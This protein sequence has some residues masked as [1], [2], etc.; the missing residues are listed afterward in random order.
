MSKAIT[1][2][3]PLITLSKMG[4]LKI[5]RDVYDEVIIPKAVLEEIKAK[6]D[7]VAKDVVN[8]LDWLKVID[9]PEVDRKK[10][11]SILHAG[12]IEAIVLAQSIGSRYFLIID[13]QAAKRAA[14]LLNLPVTGTLGVLL[15]AKRQGILEEIAPLVELMREIGVYLSDEVIKMALSTAGE[16]SQTEQS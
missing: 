12:E 7:F 10:F 4:R 6:N 16:I 11:R 15:E 1:N 9:C 2:T 3:S 14:K 8:N 5:L 13:D